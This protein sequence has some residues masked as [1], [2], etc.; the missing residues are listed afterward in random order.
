MFIESVDGHIPSTD[1]IL[2]PNDKSIYIR[3]KCGVIR[4]S[5]LR[6]I[7]NTTYTLVRAAKGGQRNE[8]R[9]RSNFDLS[10]SSEL[11]YY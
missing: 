5:S 8:V 4:Q 3:I 9:S 6:V 7:F 11:C 1:R 10:P 2:G